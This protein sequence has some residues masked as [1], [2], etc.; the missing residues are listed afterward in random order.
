MEAV[1]AGCWPLCPERLAFP[2]YLPRA[3]SGL[4]CLYRTQA[5]L[6]KALRQMAT[7]PARVRAANPPDLGGFTL[8]QLT[9]SYEKL[10]QGKEIVE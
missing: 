5:Q 3:Y 6:E 4:P 10:L 8:A 9:P 1:L 2:G 7:A